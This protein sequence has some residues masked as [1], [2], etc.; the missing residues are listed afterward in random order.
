MPETDCLKLFGEIQGVGL[1]YR[2]WQYARVNKLKGYIKNLPDGTVEC[3]LINNQSEIDKLEDW[4]KM[5]F[6][7][8]KIEKFK[9][10]LSGNFESFKIK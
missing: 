9:K 4:L 3:G 7:V 6:N 2:V 1:R 8:T 5:N 10:S